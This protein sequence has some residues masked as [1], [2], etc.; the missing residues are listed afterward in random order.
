MLRG[1]E[2]RILLENPFWEK[3]KIVAGKSYVLVVA[4]TVPGAS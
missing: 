4:I 3:R 2:Y 1:L